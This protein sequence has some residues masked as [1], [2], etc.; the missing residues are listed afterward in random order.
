MK[1]VFNS[2]GLNALDLES[3]PRNIRM[4]RM[5]ALI[6]SIK[7]KKIKVLDPTLQDTLDSI[8]FVGC[9]RPVPYDNYWP[10]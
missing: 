9:S 1:S 7:D 6:N 8:N 10:I 2:T 4:G 5:E 3:L